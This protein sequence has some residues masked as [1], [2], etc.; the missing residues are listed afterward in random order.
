MTD[1]ELR[2][3]AEK[4]TP[5][6]YSVWDG[7]PW[8]IQHPGELGNGSICEFQVADDEDESDEPGQGENNCRF[9]AA[10]DPKTILS[11]LDRLKAA[12]ANARTPGTV[13]VCQRCKEKPRRKCW[14]VDAALVDEPCPIRTKDTP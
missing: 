1:D 13:E 2:R 10:C 5:G 14:L 7:N 8:F 3:L 6:P 9:F 4:A 12:E 11:L